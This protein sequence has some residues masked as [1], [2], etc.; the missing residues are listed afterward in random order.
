MS[1]YFKSRGKYNFNPRSREGSDRMTGSNAVCGTYFNPRSREGSDSA[2]FGE[3]P[4][5]DI[6]IHAPVKGATLH[7]P[8]L[9]GNPEYFNPRSREGSDRKSRRII[10]LSRH[11]NPRSREGS[12]IASL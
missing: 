9:Q 6:S 3:I 5:E 8:R 7:K 12:D 2:G 11:F 10:S 4:R 1:S